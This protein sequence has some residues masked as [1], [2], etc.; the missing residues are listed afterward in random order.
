PQLLPFFAD[1]GQ[2]YRKAVRAFAGASRRYLQLDAVFVAI[3]GDPKYRK[4]MTDRGDNPE[5]LGEVSA[6]LSNTA[7]SG[8]RCD[9]TITMPLSRGNYKSA[10]RGSGGYEAVQEILFNK[11]KGHGYFMQYDDPRSGGFEPLR[12]VP[13]GKLVVLGVETT[14]S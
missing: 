5:R 2:A 8:I 9:M 12:M 14:K 1:L 13:K 11:I 4:Q 6:D 7:M 10:F 3:L